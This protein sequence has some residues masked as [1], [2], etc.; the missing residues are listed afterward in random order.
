MKNKFF[1]NAV[2][3]GEYVKT[4]YIIINISNSIAADKTSIPFLY[5]LLV[6]FHFFIYSFYRFIELSSK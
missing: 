3:N 2:T 6:S 5:L 4:Q 1:F